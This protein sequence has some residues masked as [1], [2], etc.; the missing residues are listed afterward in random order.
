MWIWTC[1]S[2]TDFEDGYHIY[3]KM[4]EAQNWNG[5]LLLETSRGCHQIVE[6]LDRQASE[7]GF[8]Q[9]MQIHILPSAAHC[10]VFLR[11]DDSTNL[12]SFEWKPYSAFL[13]LVMLLLLLLLLLLLPPPLPLAVN[14]GP[15]QLTSHLPARHAASYSSS[16]NCESFAMPPS[17]ASPV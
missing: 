10:W 8:L 1:I 9:N 14:S 16:R 6:Q 15:K 12:Y 3:D 2:P 4:T 13:S 17:W 5:G 11:E 7:S